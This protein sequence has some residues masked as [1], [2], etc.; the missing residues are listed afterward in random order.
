MGDD[1]SWPAD[2]P[3]QVNVDGAVWSATAEAWRSMQPGP[4]TRNDVLMVLVRVTASRPIPA[5]ARMTEV[6][7][8]HGAGS[9]R[10]E[11]KEEMPRGAGARSIDLMIRDAPPWPFGDSLTVLVRVATPGS[12]PFV[13]GTRT[14]IARVD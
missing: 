4:G 13:M 1:Q 9:W 5:G 6:T 11:A 3:A 12:A 7:L 14:V 2:A 8:R 10:G